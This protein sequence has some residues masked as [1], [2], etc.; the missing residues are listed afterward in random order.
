MPHRRAWSC[1]EQ[2]A[3]EVQ[4]T[5]MQARLSGLSGGVTAVFLQKPPIFILKNYPILSLIT[6][7]LCMA[8]RVKYG[9][10]THFSVNAAVSEDANFTAIE[11]NLYL[12]P[13]CMHVLCL[14]ATR[15]G[16]SFNHSLNVVTQPPPRARGQAELELYIISELEAA[17]L[18]RNP[19][20]AGVKVP[21][22]SGTTVPSSFKHMTWPCWAVNTERKAAGACQ[23]ISV[24]ISFLQFGF[25]THKKCFLNNGYSVKPRT[26]T[27]KI[28]ITQW[29]F[30][31]VIQKLAEMLTF[32]CYYCMLP[33]HTSTFQVIKIWHLFIIIN[34]IAIIIRIIDP[35][36]IKIKIN[37]WTFLNY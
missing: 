10:N 20:T 18:R 33:P 4:S 22:L 30:V 14:S 21:L 2:R 26:R 11:G 1:F 15:R 35:E 36:H 19:S 28:F 16:W 7:P 3:M 23:R 12:F 17:C 13:T 32:S 31:Y 9:T 34:N 29:D 24:L 8:C 37:E 27:M 6:S 5:S 25:N